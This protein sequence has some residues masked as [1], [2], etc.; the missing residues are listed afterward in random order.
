M[1]DAGDLEAFAIELH[2]EVL[3]EA[4]AVNEG[5][6]LPEQF[7][8]WMIGVLSDAGE[9]DDGEVCYYQ[10]RGIEVSGYSLDEE[11]ATLD[12]LV[13]RY[14]GGEPPVT[15][16]RADVEAGFRR[17]QEFYDRGRQGL[18]RSMEEAS[19]AFDMAQTIHAV[20]DD[21]RSLRLFYLTDGLTTLENTPTVEH[22]GVTV[23]YHVWDL[24]RVHRAVSSGHV[25]EPI[26]VD[27]ISLFGSPLRCVTAGTGEGD[28]TAYLA[29]IPGQVLAEIYERFGPRLLE[30]NVR[31]F[32]QARNKVNKGIRATIVNEPA[33]FLAFNNGITITAS[34]LEVAAFPD[35]GIGIAALDDLQIVNG[36]QT[37]ASIYAAHRRDD[38]DLSRLAVAA[39]ITVVRPEL[40]D[41]FVPNITRYA[42]SQNRINEADFYAND[43]FHVEI[44]QLSRTV[45][46]PA[47][48]GAQRQTKWFYERARGQYQ[49]ELAREGT[50]GRQRA[51]KGV[52]PT[53]QK[54][55]KTDLAKF[56]NAWAALPH[57]VSLGA[58]KNFR[59]FAVRLAERGR[60]VATLDYFRRVIAKAIIFRQT[61][62]IVS[63]QNFGG[64]R[65]NIVAYTVA[66]LSHA[67]QQ[68]LDLETIWRFQRLDDALEV[69][70]AAVA[71]AVRGV[72]IAPPRGGNVTEW[73]KR[74]DCWVAVLRLEVAEIATLP[75]S[76]LMAPVAKRKIAETLED[77]V[78]P[79]E[80]ELISR[81]AAIPASTW[82]ELSHWAK[83]TD[84][85]QGW[86]RAIAFSLG[87]I[88]GNGGHPSRKQATQAE[89]MIIEAARLGFRIAGVD[90]TSSP[91]SW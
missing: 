36:G 40:L 89:K 28:Y 57:V 7:T 26:S 65:A 58:E 80:D 34:R 72:I 49:D 14:T 59:D 79:S 38:A 55:T 91:E 73:C 60:I 77:Y 44:E 53:S 54:F 82:F 74:K 75:E 76:T 86:Q 41:A 18:F 83:E 88:A 3:T 63:A 87:R 1:N 71:R 46:A 12:L 45:W 56:E 69:A 29:V 35:G 37:T 90:S 39:K 52:Y 16:A 20:C 33:H 62:R 70:I 19:P 6:F 5:A 43:P 48:D 67:T 50:P 23:S 42:N 66:Y 85:L 2:Q 30:R 25:R 21:V 10:A 22:E 15:V 11:L 9:L 24:R 8:R 13:T 61:E 32:L 31:S 84:N 47:T 27:F 81:I 51:F 64:Y 17:L 78:D 4:H 68:R